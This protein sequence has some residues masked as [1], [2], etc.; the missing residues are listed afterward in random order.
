MLL[1]IE[2]I[3]WPIVATGGSD[4]QRCVEEDV[5]DELDGEHKLNPKWT[6]IWCIGTNASRLQIHQENNADDVVGID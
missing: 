5:L 2:R 6:R 4:R 3:Q 1:F